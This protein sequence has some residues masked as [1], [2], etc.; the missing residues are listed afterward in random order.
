MIPVTAPRVDVASVGCNVRGPL[1]LQLIVEWDVF[2]ENLG[3][4]MVV[5]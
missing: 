1:L 5:M 2:T 4:D 3:E